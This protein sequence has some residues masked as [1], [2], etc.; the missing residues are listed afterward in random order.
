MDTG[1]L[2]L[3]IVVGLLLVVTGPK[4][5]SAGADQKLNFGGG[6]LDAGRKRRLCVS[7]ARRHDSA[8]P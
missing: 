2:L 8:P 3:G 5:C 6:L 1:L 7:G 4:N